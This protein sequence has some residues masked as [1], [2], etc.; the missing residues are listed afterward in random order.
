MVSRITRYKLSGT[1]DGSG[2]AVVYSKPVRGAIK[3]IQVDIDGLTAG[4]DTT[5]TSDGELSAQAIL[6]LTNSI[7]NA[8]YY[9]KVPVHDVLGAAV[10]YDGTNEIYGDI[11]VFG[12]IKC[13][14]A[15]GGASKPFE[16]TVTVEEY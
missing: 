7:T 15:E 2:D 5:I 16:V 10:T 6:T 14:V 3:S 1:T 13:V 8:T 4:A 9:P 11:V 12:R